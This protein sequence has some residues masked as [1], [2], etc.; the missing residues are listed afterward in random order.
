MFYCWKILVFFAFSDEYICFCL[1]TYLHSS[2]IILSEVGCLSFVGFIYVYIYMCMYIYIYVTFLLFS[3]Y[4]IM[5]SPS[6]KINTGSFTDNFIKKCGQIFF[7]HHRILKTEAGRVK[8]NR[9]NYN[10][11]R[12]IKPGQMLTKIKKELTE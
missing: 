11:N 6:T 8:E 2:W 4:Y 1:N 5:Q 12:L 3:L 9:R 7:L 10:W